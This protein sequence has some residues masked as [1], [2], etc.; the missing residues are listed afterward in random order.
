MCGFCEKNIHGNN[1]KFAVWLMSYW[2]VTEDK[3]LPSQDPTKTVAQIE[4]CESGPHRLTGMIAP[5]PGYLLAMLTDK[6]SNE[7]NI[8]SM[9]MFNSTES[10]VVG[11]IHAPGPSGEVEDSTKNVLFLLHTEDRNPDTI[12]ADM[13]AITAMEASL[14]D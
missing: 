3:A 1:D 13:V 2:H 4:L 9:D 7:G 10:Y 11:F 12:L 14:S 8:I 5:E 6:V